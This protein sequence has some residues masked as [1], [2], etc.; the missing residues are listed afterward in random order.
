MVEGARGTNNRDPGENVDP[1]GYVGNPFN[2][3]CGERPD[4]QILIDRS[5]GDGSLQPCDIGPPPNA[6]G[7]VPATESLEFGPGE[8]VTTAL[9]DFACRFE[10][11]TTSSGACT[12]DSFGDF[13][14]LGSGT[15][16]Q[17]CYQVPQS[18]AFHLGKTVLAV[19][20]RDTQGVLGP[21]QEIVIEVEP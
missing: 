6:T 18:S 8:A 2:P 16:K 14:F 17:F 12:K 13:S 11:L 1:C 20:L 4:V 21:R 15:R 3:P 5:I 10:V 9:Q 19:Q 7:G